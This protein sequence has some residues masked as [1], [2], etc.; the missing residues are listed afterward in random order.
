MVNECMLYRS[1]LTLTLT[2]PFTYI[3]QVS[4]SHCHPTSYVYGQHAKLNCVIISVWFSLDHCR[5]NARQ[6]LITITISDI[7]HRPVFYLKRRYF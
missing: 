4:G 5:R 7:V 3:Y 6:Y 1:Y 2:H